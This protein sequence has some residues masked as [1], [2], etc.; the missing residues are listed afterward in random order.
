MENFLKCLKVYGEAI[1]RREIR[2]AASVFAPN[3]CPIRATLFFFVEVDKLNRFAEETIHG[4]ILRQV[5][6]T[7]RETNILIFRGH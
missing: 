7:A 6:F 2:T 4:Y 5:P 3:I 1:K